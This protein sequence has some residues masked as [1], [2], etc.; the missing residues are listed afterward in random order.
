MSLK[1]FLV[2]SLVDIEDD[3]VTNLNDIWMRG[4]DE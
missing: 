3:P 1:D 2:M 4:D